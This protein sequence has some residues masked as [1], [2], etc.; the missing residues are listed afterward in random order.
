MRLKSTGGSLGMK[1]PRGTE[2]LQGKSRGRAGKEDV[3]EY[4]K[5][6]ALSTILYW[7]IF[8]V[9]LVKSFSSKRLVANIGIQTSM[10]LSIG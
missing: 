5:V 6:L 10:C 4:E 1:R 8:P 3:A 9:T 7:C 2:R